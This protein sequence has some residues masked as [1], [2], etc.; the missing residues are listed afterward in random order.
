[1]AAV[2][3][4]FEGSQTKGCLKTLRL[5]QGEGPAVSEQ[6]QEAVARLQLLAAEQADSREEKPPRP[7]ENDVQSSGGR[8]A[9]VPETLAGPSCCQCD[10]ALPW[11]S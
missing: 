6:R 10:P 3:F 8:G 4:A 1:M 5:Q 11:H 9:A 7:S 2:K